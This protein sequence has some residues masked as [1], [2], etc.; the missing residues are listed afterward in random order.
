MVVVHELDNAVVETLVIGHVGVGRVDSNDLADE[1]GQGPARADQVV[2]DVAGAQLVA[3]QDLLFEPR[4]GIGHLGLGS[5][6][7]SDRHAKSP[8]GT[9]PIVRFGGETVSRVA[10]AV[11]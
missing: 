2:E 1:L 11:K 8:L 4:V 9:L 5:P 7:G 3:L 10:V 6:A